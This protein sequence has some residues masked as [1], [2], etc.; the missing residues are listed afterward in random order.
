MHDICMGNASIKEIS[1]VTLIV[2]LCAVQI[3]VAH[4]EPDIIQFT[5]TASYSR[6]SLS[7]SRPAISDVTD[8]GKHRELEKALCQKLARRKETDSPGFTDVCTFQKITRAVTFKN[9][10]IKSF[11]ASTILYLY[12]YM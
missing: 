2:H 3:E 5:G 10:T 1:L 4:F 7:V 6:L 8:S 12:N 11:F 9:S